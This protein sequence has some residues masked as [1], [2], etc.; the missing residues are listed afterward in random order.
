MNNNESRSVTMHRIVHQ[1]CVDKSS[2]LNEINS[3]T[4]NIKWRRKENL[5]RMKIN[6]LFYVLHIVSNS[7]NDAHI[8]YSHCTIAIRHQ[9]IEGKSLNQTL[10]QIKTNI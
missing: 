1:I 5:K 9:K 8:F 2:N 4:I 10:Q 3:K 6:S 7:E